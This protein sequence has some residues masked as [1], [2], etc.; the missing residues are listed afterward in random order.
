VEGNK[1]CNLHDLKND[2]DTRK[3]IEATHKKLQYINF[4]PAR[5]EILTTF[6]PQA[7]TSALKVTMIIPLFFF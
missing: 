3:L 5:V 6:L 2:I 1:Q 7:S 4:K